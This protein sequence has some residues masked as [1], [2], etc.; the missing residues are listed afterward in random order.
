MTSRISA[1]HALA[2]PLAALILLGAAACGS[3]DSAAGPAP[4]TSTPTTTAPTTA[5]PTTPATSEAPEANPLSRFED[6]PAVKALRTF[7]ASVGTSIN[8][9]DAS[10][11][12]AWPVMTVHGRTVFQQVAASDVRLFYPGPLPITPTRVQHEGA[13]TRINSCVWL[14]GW[15]QDPKTKLPADGRKVG[16]IAW[17]LHRQAGVWKVDDQVFVNIDCSKVSVKGVAW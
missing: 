6:D 3:G 10:L 13:T 9:D 1:S 2:A 11:K 4:L 5:P 17:V 16:P 7:A 8:D 12:A 14:A 15:G